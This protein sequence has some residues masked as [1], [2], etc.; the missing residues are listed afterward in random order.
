[1]KI[2]LNIITIA[3]LHTSI[4]VGFK[5]RNILLQKGT[6]V[7]TRSGSP[8]TP[9]SSPLAP[10][11]TRSSSPLAPHDIGFKGASTKPVANPQSKPLYDPK[12]QVVHSIHPS[13]GVFGPGYKPTP[14]SP[15]PPLSVNQKLR[16]L[17]GS[18]PI[19]TQQNLR[20]QTNNNPLFTKP[21]TKAPAIDALNQLPSLVKPTTPP[22]SIGSP[23]PVKLKALPPESP[24]KE[25]KSISLFPQRVQPNKPLKPLPSE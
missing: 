8:L 19:Q 9:R 3:I 17:F 2:L 11:V 7:A 1:M 21:L 5:G 25:P 23:S 18:L 10:T 15:A 12:A 14:K 20:G 22:S 6:P 4:A 13:S 24:T 16:K